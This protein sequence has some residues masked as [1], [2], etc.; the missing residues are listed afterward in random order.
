MSA[1]PA[2]PLELALQSGRVGRNLDAISAV[3]MAGQGPFPFT[4]H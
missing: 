2:A 3:K 4:P 1:S